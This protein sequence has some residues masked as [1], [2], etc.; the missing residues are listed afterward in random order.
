MNKSFNIIFCLL[1]IVVLFVPPSSSYGQLLFGL[2][3]GLTH[4]GLTGDAPE[5]ASFKRLIGYTIGVHFEYNLTK[6]IIVG[7]GT[8]YYRTGTIVTYD[9][10]EKETKDSFNI[11]LSYISFPVIFKVLTGGKHTYFTSGLDYRQ[12]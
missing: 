6:D 11:S 2:N 7:L 10:G 4:N 3:T 8:R 12:L 9:V 5:D 1:I